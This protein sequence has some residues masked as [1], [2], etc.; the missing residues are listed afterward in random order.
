MRLVGSCLNGRPHFVEP[1]SETPLGSLVG[2][3]RASQPTSNYNQICHKFI[4]PLRNDAC[5]GLEISL[6]YN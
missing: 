1:Y 3:F 6:L 4:L 5:L 2:G